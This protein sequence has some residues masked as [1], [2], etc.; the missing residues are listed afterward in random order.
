MGAKKIW[1]ARRA[2]EQLMPVGELDIDKL[3]EYTPPK[4]YIK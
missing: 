3:P 1:D 4:H 2:T